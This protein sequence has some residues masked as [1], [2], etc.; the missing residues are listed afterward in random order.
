[1]NDI[2]EL[3][4]TKLNIK[5]YPHIH[6]PTAR[7]CKCFTNPATGRVNKVKWADTGVVTPVSEKSGNFTASPEAME[8]ASRELETYASGLFGHRY[9]VPEWF[10][11]T[12]PIEHF[13]TAF[14]DAVHSSVC[15]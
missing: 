1:M 11:W 10:D 3:T 13:T 4:K 14:A 7:R 5:K 2:N 15:K 8:K 9:M 6:I 12:G